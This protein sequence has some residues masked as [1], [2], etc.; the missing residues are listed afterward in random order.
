MNQDELRN[1]FTSRNLTMKR[2]G[3]LIN[4]SDTAMSNAL[5][6]FKVNGKPLYFSIEK[7]QRINEALPIMADEIEARLLKFDEERSA[8]EG[9]NRYDPGCIEQLRRV[10][11]Y[12]NVKGLTY[13][14]LEWSQP[15]CNAFFSQNNPGR[16]HI[17]RHEVTA[18]NT[19]LLAIAGVL[20]GTEVVPMNVE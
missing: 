19:E 20:R 6:H 17:K 5:N 12:F 2:L 16:G 3:E 9:N 1:Y 13:R 4:Q 7:L 14:V 15:K 10:G 8:K 11:D 18:I